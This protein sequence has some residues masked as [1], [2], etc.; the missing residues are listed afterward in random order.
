MSSYCGA[1]HNRSLPMPRAGHHPIPTPGC[2]AIRERKSLDVVRYRS[3]PYTGEYRWDSPSTTSA[4]MQTEDGVAEVTPIPWTHSEKLCARRTLLWVEASYEPAAPPPARAGET[5]AAIARHAA[6]FIA[7][8][9]TLEFGLGILPDT[10]CAAL[11]DRKSLR[12]HSG[13]IGDGV[14]ELMRQGAVAGADC[15]MLIGTR[16]L[17]DHAHGNP[18]VRLRS[19]E[20]THDPAYSRPAAVRG[21]HFLVESISPPV[22]AEVRRAASG[23]V[24]GALVSAR[25]HFSSGVPLL[26]CL[27]GASCAPCPVRFR[28]RAAKRVSSSPSAA[29]RTC[30]AVH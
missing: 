11:Q 1:G 8:G 28:H 10:V 25:R 21:R 3:P 5:E 27:R 17:F 30:V 15:A 23:R 13:T 29:R 19:T 26:C 22:N 6:A 24:R 20:Y 14:A 7:D 18:A 16:K 4:A 2:A 9:A 12:V